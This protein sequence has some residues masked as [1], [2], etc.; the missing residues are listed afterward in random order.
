MNKDLDALWQ[1][2]LADTQVR[3]IE[4]EMAALDDGARLK[5]LCEKLEGDLEKARKQLQGLQSQQRD[6]ELSL[7]AAEEK[8]KGFERELYGGLVTNPKELRDMEQEIGLLGEQADRLETRILEIMEQADQVKAE[9]AELEK[10]VRLGRKKLEEVLRAYQE[11]RAAL[12]QEAAQVKEERQRWAAGIA[13]RDWLARYEA[14]RA[15]AGGIAMALV[16]RAACGACGIVV[17]SLSARRA[18]QEGRLLTCEGCGRLL[19][20]GGET[21]E[22]R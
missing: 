8:K 14:I 10:K 19:Y 17:P 9:V 5:R 2:H 21:N 15:S 1:M 4:T 22:A 12:E 3:R 7:A 16:E 20:S 18:Q 6:A 13:Q 11:R